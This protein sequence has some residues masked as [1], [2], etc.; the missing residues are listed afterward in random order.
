MSERIGNTRESAGARKVPRGARRRMEL[1]DIAERIFLER[2]FTATT[3]KAI[4]ERAGASKETIYRHF[5]SKELLFAEIVSRKARRISGS[6]GALASKARAE[7][8]LLEFGIGLLRAILTGE[9]AFLFR[10]VVAEVDRAPKLGDLFYERGP[11]LTAKRL[12]EYIAAASR[13]GELDCDNPSVAARLFLGAVV[14]HYHVR[15]LVQSGWKPLTDAQIGRHA[16][17]ATSMFLARYGLQTAVKRRST[18]TRTR[19]GGS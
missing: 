3:M 6:E 9:G 13:R 8:V 16:E 19:G 2:G 1:I 17:A 10:T 14:S 7:T 5:A 15:R 18:G 12:T 11:G 4:A